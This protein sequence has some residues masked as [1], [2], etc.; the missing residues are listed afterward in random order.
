MTP[1]QPRIVGGPGPWRHSAF[2]PGARLRYFATP[3]HRDYRVKTLESSTLLRVLM[4][5]RESTLLSGRVKRIQQ[6]LERELLDPWSSRPTSPETE[7]AYLRETAQEFYWNELEWEKLTGEE[8]LDEEFLTEMAFPG[9]LA[10]VRGLLLEEAAPD[11]PVPPQPNP[12]V[13][14][15]LMDFLAQR[16]VELEEEASCCDGE[17]KDHREAEL[18]M[19]SRLVDLLLYH[20]YKLEPQ[21]VVRVENA[22]TPR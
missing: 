12:S 7:L 4:A 10:F 3:R 13:V 11:S 22:L 5:H 1:D 21:E 6:V 14:R 16:V 19:T 20:Y 2:P 17:E 15:D 18:S 9:F 8:Q